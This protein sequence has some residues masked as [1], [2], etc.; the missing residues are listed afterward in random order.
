M[1]KHERQL[2]HYI[3]NAIFLANQNYG[4]TFEEY[5]KQ[6]RKK[7]GRGAKVDYEKEYQN[8]LEIHKTDAK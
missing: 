6:I 8:Y 7:A 3:K 5:K 4:L 2:E 1:S